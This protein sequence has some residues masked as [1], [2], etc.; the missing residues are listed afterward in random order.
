M[1]TEELRH[2]PG[3][4]TPRRPPGGG[5]MQPIGRPEGRDTFML[6]AAEFHAR[7]AALFEATGRRELAELARRRE[8]EARRRIEER[9]AGRV[10]RTVRG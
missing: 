9:R 8:S 10:R 7:A 4:P 1:S 3:T 5:W 6:A 2:E